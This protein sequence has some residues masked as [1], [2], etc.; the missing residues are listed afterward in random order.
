MNTSNLFVTHSV[1]LT[2]FLVLIGALSLLA[3]VS[4]TL[5]PIAANSVQ[6]STCDR[7]SHSPFPD[8]LSQ[9]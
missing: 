4:S 6:Q 5:D 2:A 1:V 7:S 3:Q 8:Y 9:R